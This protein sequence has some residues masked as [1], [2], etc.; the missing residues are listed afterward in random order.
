MEEHSDTEEERTASQPVSQPAAQPQHPTTVTVHTRKPLHR[1][2]SAR[3]PSLVRTLGCAA[4][5]ALEQGE[6]KKK[7]RKEKKRIQNEPLDERK[8][9]HSCDSR[10]HTLSILLSHLSF[11]V[12]T[13]L[14]L[15]R[16][17]YA[18]FVRV[19]LRILVRR[20]LFF[21][22]A[23]HHHP[24]PRSGAAAAEGREC[25][26]KGTAAEAQGPRTSVRGEQREEPGVVLTISRVASR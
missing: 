25:L 16:D 18:F 14:L 8:L 9:H 12:L 13:L 26:A 17:R 24:F 22:S 7:N 23:V 5:C 11:V 10:H 19:L 4:A 21:S 1:T 15:L 3:S 6:D 20:S 2:H